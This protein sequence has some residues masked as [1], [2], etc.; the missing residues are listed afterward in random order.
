MEVCVET[1]I[2]GAK[3]IPCNGNLNFSSINQPD[4][5]QN[6]TITCHMYF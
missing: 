6:E 1:E 5:N 3:H 2:P 4:I